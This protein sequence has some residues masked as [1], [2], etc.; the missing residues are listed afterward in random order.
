MV[1]K[2]KVRKKK[3]QMN[4]GAKKQ[5]SGRLSAT[6]A[7]ELADLAHEVSQPLTAVL[8]Y[9]Q[10]AKRILKGREPQVQKILSYIIDD[11]QRATCVIQR[12]RVLLKHSVP[13]V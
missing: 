7:R 11:D 13:K 3:I 8:S 9:A 2:N 6:R 12:L 10:A 1:K 5:R 4:L